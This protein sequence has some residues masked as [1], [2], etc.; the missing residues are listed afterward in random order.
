MAD[1]AD[2][3]KAL[4]ELAERLRSEHGINAERIA[5][6]RAREHHGTPQEDIWLMTYQ[7]LKTTS[8]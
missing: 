4:S 3:L 6:C 8:V 2:V 1:E 5:V 7:L